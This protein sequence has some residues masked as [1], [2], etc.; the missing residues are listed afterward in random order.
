[1]TPR[2]ME[3]TADGPGI[4]RDGPLNFLGLPA[5]RPAANANVCASG[6]LA[7]DEASFRDGR[8]PTLGR[9]LA[10]RDKPLVGAIHRLAAELAELDEE[11]NRYAP[12]S[13]PARR[14]GMGP[15]PCRRNRSDQRRHAWPALEDAMTEPLY[16]SL[17]SIPEK[18]HYIS[19][20]GE[21]AYQA[22]PWAPP[23]KF[24]HVQNL[25]DLIDEKTKLDFIRERGQR[26]FDEMVARAQRPR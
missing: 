6:R 26:V 23:Q 5:Y 2:T 16:R 9:Q 7:H 22:L 4:F 25:S 11:T 24:A 1:M 8:D 10:A 12:R 13:G 3:S 21:P 17:M 19:M 14:A 15:C 18:A 20:H